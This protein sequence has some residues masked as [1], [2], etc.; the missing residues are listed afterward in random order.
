MAFSLFKTV[1]RWYVLHPEELEKLDLDELPTLISREF[2]HTS[3]RIVYNNSILSFDVPL[4]NG[5]M[6]GVSIGSSP[7]YIQSTEYKNGVLDGETTLKDT[8]GRE[9]EKGQYVDGKKNGLWIF[10]NPQQI[11]KIT[12]NN[13]EIVEVEIENLLSNYRMIYRHHDG[14]ISYSFYSHGIIRKKYDYYGDNIYHGR[15]QEYSELGVL[16]HDGNYKNGK[17]DGIQ[18]YYN[19]T[20]IL[21]GITSYVNGKLHGWK[22]DIRHGIIVYECYYINDKKVGLSR[23][24]NEHRVLTQEEYF[25]NGIIKSKKRWNDEG[26]LIEEIVYNKESGVTYHMSTSNRRTIKKVFDDE[27]KTLI[28]R[29]LSIDN[30]KIFE[31]Y[32]DKTDLKYVEILMHSKLIYKY[33][34]LDNGNDIYQYWDLNGNLLS[35]IITTK[36]LISEIVSNEISHELQQYIFDIIY[37]DEPQI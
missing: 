10:T 16:I 20:G 3:Y 32:Y 29:E 9:I 1:K 6:H 37:Y 31:K 25:V 4:K 18:K 34:T 24:Y 12:Y 21:T 26:E 23:E 36:C 15:Y 35:Y 28:Y 8:S 7:L 14:I 5:K 11:K 22:L 17:L 13:D 30:E 19:T 27:G 2:T 33:E